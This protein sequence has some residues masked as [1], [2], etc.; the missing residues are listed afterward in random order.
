MDFLEEKLLD[1]IKK[2]GE[3]D[4][5]G[6]KPSFVL[7]ELDFNSSPQY[8]RKLGKH[9]LDSNSNRIFY[10]D[11][12]PLMMKPIF[13]RDFEESIFH[14]ID[15]RDDYVLIDVGSGFGAGVIR[16][17]ALLKPNVQVIMIDN[18]SRET[19][20]KQI[21]IDKL[22][23]G[24]GFRIKREIGNDLA[25]FIT[26]T[27]ADNKL[28]N[29]R[30]VQH[31][32]TYENIGMHVLDM[33]KGKK[34]FVTNF[35]SPKG[36]G[37]LATRFAVESNAERLYMTQNGLEAISPGASHFRMLNA[38]LHKSGLTDYEISKIQRLM[39]DKREKGKDK[40]DF[41]DKY[42][43]MFGTALK[44][45]FVAAQKNLLDTNGYHVE[46]TQNKFSERYS[47]YHS[48]RKIDI[49]V[50]EYHHTP[51]FYCSSLHN[52]KAS[53]KLLIPVR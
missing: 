42:E 36:F 29:V 8:P 19:L 15:D 52:L 24:D 37:N 47:Y 53:K 2:Y 48:N 18:M 17:F 20:E 12:T 26:S 4:L 31:D 1:F 10:E 5:S 14:E 45:L 49:T 40:Y 25:D 44:L 23:F 27:Y 38:F 6:D 43:K 7:D 13:Q 35:W 32:L 9:I 51:G 41:K 16:T 39:Y 3:L 11:Y 22:Q 21:E 30:Y 28:G 46:L 33:V 34:V 50:Q